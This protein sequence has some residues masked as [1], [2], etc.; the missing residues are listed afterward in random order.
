MVN[1]ANF[2]EQERQELLN[3]IENSNNEEYSGVSTA[4]NG[5]D[6][7]TVWQRA[8]QLKNSGASEQQV[9]TFL[10]QMTDEKYIT[11]SQ[12]QYIALQLQ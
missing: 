10:D 5:R 3:E 4:T 7:Q 6:F 1:S 9:M 11:S 12:A 2:T 8:V